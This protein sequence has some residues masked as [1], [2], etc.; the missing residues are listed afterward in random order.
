MRC[1]GLRL[2]T[3]Q[4]LL[5]ISPAYERV[6]GRSIGG[7]YV[8]PQSFFEAIHSDDQERVIAELE[9]QK[10]GQP[11]DREYRIRRPD[12][13]VRWIWD[14]GY[15]VRD[16]AEIVIRFVGVAVDITDRKQLEEINFDRRKKWK[17]WDAWLGEW[18]MT[19]TTC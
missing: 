13:T 10:K 17:R 11:F 16:A 5:Y 6:W 1:S 8:T 7:L 12:G 4:E 19:S 9:F 3:F 2:R 14:R 15:P 18:R